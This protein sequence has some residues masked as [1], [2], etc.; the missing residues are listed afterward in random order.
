MLP[1]PYEAFT[2]IVLERKCTFEFMENSW[3]LRERKGAGKK[4]EKNRKLTTKT[5]MGWA[6]LL[7]AYHLLKH[8][9]WET[10]TISLQVGLGSPRLG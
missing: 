8:Q 5:C 7:E 3:A 2:A 1:N 4:P 9:L 6:M 10:L